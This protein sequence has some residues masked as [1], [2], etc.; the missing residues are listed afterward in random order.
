MQLGP[1]PPVRVTRKLFV[2]LILSPVPRM[3]MAVPPDLGP[4]AG[5][6]PITVGATTVN[7]DAPTTLTDLAPRCK[8]IVTFLKP[9]PL[10][11]EVVTQM[12]CTPG[13]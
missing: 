10:V 9:G 11:N 1:L 7:I 5:S 12:I 6:T 3:V 8:K 4:N 2:L 13:I